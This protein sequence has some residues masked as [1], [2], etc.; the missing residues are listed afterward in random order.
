MKIKILKF[1]YSDYCKIILLALL[2][3]VTL[4]LIASSFHL[5]KSW[6]IGLLFIIV[7]IT[8]SIIMGRWIKK[9]QQ[10]TWVF[11]IFPGAFLVLVLLRYTLSIYAYLF[12]VLYGLIEYLTFILTKKH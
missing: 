2:I 6:R 3:A 4:P 5:G 1:W 11:G 9:T 12:F 7:N 10:P 8:V